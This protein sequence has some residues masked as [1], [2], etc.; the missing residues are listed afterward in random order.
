[1]AVP[2]PACGAVPDPDDATVPDD[3]T[4]ALTL[5]PA[6]GGQR[7]VHDCPGEQALQAAQLDEVTP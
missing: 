2:C 7:L 6:A 1:M 3:E 4:L 5:G